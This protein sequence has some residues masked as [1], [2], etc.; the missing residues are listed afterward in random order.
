MY[1]FNTESN[2][3]SPCLDDNNRAF[4]SQMR[5]YQHI[6]DDV[7]EKNN[8][9]VRLERRVKDVENVC[10]TISKQLFL[11]LFLIAKT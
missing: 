6:Q 11:S 2:L 5:V 7:S 10:P 4:E 9:I 1:F 3:K 8:E